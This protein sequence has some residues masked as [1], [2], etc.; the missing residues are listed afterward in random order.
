MKCILVSDAVFFIDLQVN[1]KYLDGNST[2]VT[3]KY[4]HLYFTKE[5]T[6]PI[7]PFKRILP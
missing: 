3:Y 5:G 6:K 4:G 1:K 2:K 7:Q